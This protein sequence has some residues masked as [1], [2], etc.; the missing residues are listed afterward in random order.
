METFSYKCINT[1]K[2]DLNLKFNIYRSLE[3]LKGVILYFH[4]G[5]LV[6]GSEMTFQSFIKKNFYLR[7]IQSFLLIIDWLLKQSLKKSY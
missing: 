5:G 3:G 1:D 6:Y 7:A 2:K 4:G